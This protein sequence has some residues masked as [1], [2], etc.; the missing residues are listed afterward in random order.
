MMDVSGM[1]APGVGNH[2]VQYRVRVST[3]GGSRFESK[4][5]VLSSVPPF[6]PFSL[7]ELSNLHTLSL[8][9]AAS[10]STYLPCSQPALR[11]C[12]QYPLLLSA[13][14]RTVQRQART[15]RIGQ[16]MRGGRSFTAPFWLSQ[17]LLARILFVESWWAHHH[18][19]GDSPA[20]LAVQGFV[21]APAAARTRYNRYYSTTTSRRPR[22]CSPFYASAIDSTAGPPQQQQQQDDQS[23][24]RELL[25]EVR[26]R[27]AWRQNPECS[28][29]TFNYLLWALVT[30]QQQQQ[31]ASSSTPAGAASGAAAASRRA[32]QILR[33]MLQAGRAGRPAMR[34]NVRTLN[35]VLSAYAAAAAAK[36]GGRPSAASA[37]NRAHQLLRE[38]QEQ[39]YPDG[40]VEEPV[41]IV[42]YNIVL[43]AFGKAG[44]P[45][46]AAELFGELLEVQQEDET[47]ANDSASAKSSSLRTTRRLRPD[48]YTYNALLN[49]YAVAGQTDQVGDLFRQMRTGDPRPTIHTYNH[50]LYAYAKSSATAAAAAMQQQQQQQQTRTS[51]AVSGLVVVGRAAAAGTVGQW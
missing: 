10:S 27:P 38:W 36:Q 2:L 19:P 47:T 39:W 44:C 20:V 16:S 35:H 48:V 9:A 25:R 45:N 29:R 22:C 7:F 42:S 11:C 4:I 17:F 31:Q 49:A 28:T 15:E 37:A 26:V 23:L 13:W 24:L 21:V 43:S 14:P 46:R 33:Y 1:L 50:V 6:L 34:P 5:R 12:S 41:D 18:R 40:W 32:E 51:R 30:K 8:H 3:F